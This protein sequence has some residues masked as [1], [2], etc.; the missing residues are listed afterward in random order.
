MA[1]PEEGT[2]TGYSNADMMLLEKFGRYVGTVQAIT[3]KGN[4]NGYA[5]YLV[6]LPDFRERISNDMVI[7]ITY[8][9]ED[10]ILHR[11]TLSE[12]ELLGELE[13]EKSIPFVFKKVRQI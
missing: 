2:F 7:T 10:N 11:I 8:I 6:L 3:W 13:T 9:N 12:L 4:P 5:G 1:L